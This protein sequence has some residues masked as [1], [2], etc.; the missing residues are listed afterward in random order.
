MDKNRHDVYF[1]HED[2]S[3]LIDL[4]GHGKNVSKLTFNN[5]K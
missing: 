5:L 3:D 1:V 4:P 2:L